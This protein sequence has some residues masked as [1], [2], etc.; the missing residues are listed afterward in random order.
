LAQP[1]ALG[2]KRRGEVGEAGQVGEPALRVGGSGRDHDQQAGGELLGQPGGEGRGAGAGEAGDA[3]RHPL[4][5]NPLQ[6]GPRGG[7]ASEGVQDRVK[8]HR[9]WRRT[10]ARPTSA[11][12]SSSAVQS[13]GPRRSLRAPARNATRGATARS[14]T[15]VPGQSA[16]TL[17]SSERAR[18]DSRGS[19][20][21]LSAPTV[22]RS[23]R[24]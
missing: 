20:F 6:D 24:R 22:S 17:A 1:F 18:S 12:P 7:G 10:L 23:A 5:G 8:H 16:R 9:P 11:N 21:T 2:V 15:R 14:T 3:Q 4:P 13:R 19:K